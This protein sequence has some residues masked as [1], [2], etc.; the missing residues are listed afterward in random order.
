M[1]LSI[2]IGRNCKKLYSQVTSIFLDLSQNF[3]V[4]VVYDGWVIVLM[5]F[6]LVFSFPCISAYVTFLCLMKLFLPK[7]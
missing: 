4:F 2:I 5:L 7:K 6:F 1:I 3:E